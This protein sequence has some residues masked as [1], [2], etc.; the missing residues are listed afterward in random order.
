MVTFVFSVFQVLNELGDSS[1]DWKELVCLPSLLRKHQENPFQVT[2]AQV[3][4]FP[5]RFCVVLAWTLQ[6]HELIITAITAKAL[7]GLN[8]S[9]ARDLTSGLANGPVSLGEGLE[10]SKDAMLCFEVHHFP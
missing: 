10:S 5:A 8:S 6:V 9:E 4:R 1:G 7:R 3:L 2:E